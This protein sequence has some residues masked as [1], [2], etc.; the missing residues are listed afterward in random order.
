MKDFQDL[1]IAVFAN[2][3][4]GF[5][6]LVALLVLGFFSSA[7]LFLKARKVKKERRFISK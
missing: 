5:V 3:N 1:F 2:E 7:R 4:F 6:A